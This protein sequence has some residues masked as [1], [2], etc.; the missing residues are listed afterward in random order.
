MVTMTTENIT[1]R[2]ADTTDTADLGNGR[3]GHVAYGKD[4]TTLDFTMTTS[5]SSA[6][7][8]PTFRLAF[9]TLE[10]SS[11]AL[12][13]LVLTDDNRGTADDAVALF[14]FA[15]QTTA[16]IMGGNSTLYVRTG[17]KPLRAVLEDF[18]YDALRA[19]VDGKFG[20]ETLLMVSLAAVKQ[21]RDQAFEAG[22]AGAVDA[23]A[24]DKR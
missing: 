21:R 1:A 13:R 22:R 7:D 18:A 15:A 2:A 20:P 6:S 12:S 5:E 23:L 10:T 3:L 14:G 9:E 11:G 24:G 19:E 16:R 17:C 4:G 8:S